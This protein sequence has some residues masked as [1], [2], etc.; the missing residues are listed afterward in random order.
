MLGLGSSLTTSVVSSGIIPS[1]V[2]GLALWFKPDTT[3]AILTAAEWKDSSGNNNHMTQGTS[4]N[5][6]DVNADGGLDFEG[7][8]SD[9][10][11]LTNDVIIGAQEA[12]GVFLVCDIESFDSQNTFLG[13]GIS[14]A[15]L[16]IQNASRMR[17][18]TSTS[19]DTD[20]IIYAT[21]SFAAGTKM[22]L[23]FQRESGST[24]EIKT[25]KNGSELDIDSYG[26]SSN[27][28]N[29]GAITFDRV[30]QRAGDRFFDGDINELIVYDADLS[31]ADRNGIFQYLSDLHGVALS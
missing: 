13:T 15:F 12:I 29:T 30:G 18:K 17:F 14:G 1:D 22:M 16:E 25:F 10:Y 21:N 3:G 31:D 9:S 8:Q 5:Q 23:Y 26:A 20:I 4:G 2:G 19:S 27:N 6:A 24:G 11:N 28:E 7:S